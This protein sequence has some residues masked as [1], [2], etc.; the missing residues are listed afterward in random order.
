MIIINE[1]EFAKIYNRGDKTL[2]EIAAIYNVSVT[3]VADRIKRW[4]LQGREKS[5][6][7]KS[8]IGKTFGYWNVFE[9]AESEN[10]CDVKSAYWKC[11]CICGIERVVSGQALRKGKSKSCGCVGRPYWHTGYEE[12]AT[13]RWNRYIDRAVRAGFEFTI[14][15]ENAWGI[16]I[17]QNK[18]CALS[19]I[20]I[21]FAKK[22]KDCK[23]TT[24]SLD[25][26]DSLKGYV[27][28]NIQWVHKDVNMM[29]YVYDNE[30]F[31]DMCKKIAANNSSYDYRNDP[32]AEKCPICGTSLNPKADYIL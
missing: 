31:I 11:K 22:V 7:L 13:S 14:S 4:N 5:H 24:A 12:I 28:G 25:R 23:G 26:V 17:K 29:K 3:V 32:L 8:L 21:Y 27:D 19:G 6:L 2:K 20:D 16:F 9:R 10:T 15:I 30:Y 18:K 1:Q